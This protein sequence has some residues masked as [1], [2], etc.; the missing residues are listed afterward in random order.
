[1]HTDCTDASKKQGIGSS[2][3]YSSS[4]CDPN[5]NDSDSASDTPSSTYE[6]YSEGSTSIG[7]EAEISLDETDKS[8]VPS[9]A[10]TLANGSEPASPASDRSDESRDEMVTDVAQ[11]LNDLQPVLNIIGSDDEESSEEFDERETSGH[12]D[13]IGV[14]GLDSL[15]VPE[16]KPK[17][18]R[19][20]DESDRR[21]S[22][23]VID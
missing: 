19:R 4:D 10:S 21:C 9:K 8:P 5:G 12:H 20:R 1:M 3:S 15:F 13:G 11:W 17:Q 7:S 2:D 16:W 23:L 6:T 18:R 14:G 22:I